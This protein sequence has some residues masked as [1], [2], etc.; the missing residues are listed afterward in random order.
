MSCLL[1]VPI[2]GY[3]E[4]SCHFC[5]FLKHEAENGR[6]Y[7]LSLLLKHSHES[8]L[9]IFNK[10]RSAPIEVINSSIG[11]SEA[12]IKGLNPKQAEFIAKNLYEIFQVTV[13]IKEIPNSNHFN[14]IHPFFNDGSNWKFEVLS[15]V[16]NSK[17]HLE[18]GQELEI[19]HSSSD[20][21][22][23]QVAHAH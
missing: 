4:V 16:G 5:E 20:E 17:F 2:H 12:Y 9:K 19:F 8:I 22:D 21:E 18:K 6:I 14:Q 23:D 13:K 15:E 3:Y 1:N 11:Y 10:I 7:G